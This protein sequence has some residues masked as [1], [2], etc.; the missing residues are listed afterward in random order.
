ME[1]VSTALIRAFALTD[2][3]IHKTQEQQHE[4]R[5]Q[6][7]LTDESMKNQKQ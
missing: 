2:I 5:K 7:I 4:F 6:T 1:L 3:D